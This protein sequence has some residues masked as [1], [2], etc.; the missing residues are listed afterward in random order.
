[1]FKYARFLVGNLNDVLAA[2]GGPALPLPNIPL[3]LGISFFTFHILSYLI[4]VYRGVTPPQ[5]SLAAF[6]LYIFPQLI[7]GPIIRYKQI[8]DQLGTRAVALGDV[9]YG[10][11][12]F[13]TGLAK[14]LLIADPHSCSSARHASCAPATCCSSC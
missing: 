9:E 10:V 7:A 2:V 11:L 3:P 12:R 6:A 13:V 8:A 4:D 1:M 14:K 5:Q